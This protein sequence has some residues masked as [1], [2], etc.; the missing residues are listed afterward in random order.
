MVEK[1]EEE[2]A[3]VKKNSITSPEQQKRN[4]QAG[5]GRERQGAGMGARTEQL[6]IDRRLQ[7]PP[8]P[9]HTKK[10]ERKKLPLV[11]HKSP[12]ISSVTVHKT[13]SLLFLSL[14]FYLL[15]SHALLCLLFVFFPPSLTC[16]TSLPSYFLPSLFIFS[17]LFF[18]FFVF[19][20]F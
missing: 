12:S 7:S 4:G 18:F 1:S 15:P 2:V 20:Y 10:K 14:L 3:R 9:T 11:Q 8:G 16:F 6:Y 17:I 5:A 19:V 13:T